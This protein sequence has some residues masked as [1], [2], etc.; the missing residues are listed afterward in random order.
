MRGGRWD[1]WE[2][3]GTMGDHRGPYGTTGDH[4]GPRGPR[5][6]VACHFYTRAHRS[7]RSSPLAVRRAAMQSLSTTKAAGPA[8]LPHL[9]AAAMQWSKLRDSS[10]P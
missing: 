4:G 8:S 10:N 3:L 7:S 1:R 9:I 2:P 6:R 5:G